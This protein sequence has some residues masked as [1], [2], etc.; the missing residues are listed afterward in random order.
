MNSF[1]SISPGQAFAKIRGH[2]RSFALKRKT[3]FATVPIL[4]HDLTSIPPLS[5]LL[6][7]GMVGMGMIFDETYAPFFEAAEHGV[8]DR[9]TG[10][11]PRRAGRSRDPH[12]RP[13]R[14]LSPSAAV[15]PTSAITCGENAVGDLLAS[16][17]DF[18]CVAS[19]DDKHF[20]AAKAG[21][22]G[23]Q[24]RHHRK[25]FGPESR[26]TRSARR[27][28]EREGCSRQGRLPQAPRSRSQEAA[29]AR[30]RRRPLAR[31]QRL[32]FAPRTEVDLGQPVRRWITGRNPGTYVAVHYLKLID[33]TFGGRLKSVSA[34]VNGVSS[35]RRTAPPGTRP[36]SVSSTNTRADARRPSTST[37][38]GSRRTTF[39]GYVEQEV[40]FRFD[41]GVW[42]G[43]SRKRGVELTVEGRTPHD[44]KTTINNHYNGSFLEPWG[45]RSRAA[46]GSR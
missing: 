7:G 20:A 3:R 44:L 2:L 11:F 19:P 40:Q 29:H 32:L 34:R 27:S 1:K 12:R 31:E 35:D 15:L 28:C 46:T 43:H 38:A 22:R 6:R 42:N 8:Y 23:R 24:T 18:L 13:R 37:R 21:D 41:N 10:A 36:S 25:A 39:P 4:P 45:E 16:G 14:R 17:I 5:Q 33:F 26:R 30:R 9:S